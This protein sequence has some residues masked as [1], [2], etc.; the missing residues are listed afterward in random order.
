MNGKP[1][2]RVL[3]VKLVVVAG[4][5]FGFGFALAPFYNKLCEAVGLNQIQSAD[6][7]V[8]TQVDRTRVVTLQFDSNLRDDLPWTFRPLTKSLQVHP[9]EL[10]HVLYEVKNA[11]DQPVMGQAIPSYG[12][13]LAAQYVKKLECFCFTRQ[14]LQAHETRSMAV[15]FVLTPNL[16][17]DVHT[18]TLSYTFFKVEGAGRQAG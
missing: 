7:P 10:V 6:A 9:G 3:L 16:P 12:P 15:V 5:M 11:S 18:V 8:N 1:E 17:Q 13:Q 14:Q 4:V 2:N